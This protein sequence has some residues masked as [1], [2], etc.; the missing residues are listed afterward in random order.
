MVPVLAVAEE[1]PAQ[2]ERRRLLLRC[3]QAVAL[4]LEGVPLH[5]LL[6]PLGAD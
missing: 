2:Q 6:G 5:R 3:S 1:E 4:P